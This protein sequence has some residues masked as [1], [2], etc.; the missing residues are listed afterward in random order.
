MP[1]GDWA[2]GERGLASLPGRQAEF[3]DGVKLA[4]DYAAALDCKL[5]HCHGGD[6]AG[7]TCRR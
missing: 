7:R 4:L 5:V 3:R 1:P 2:K 6:R